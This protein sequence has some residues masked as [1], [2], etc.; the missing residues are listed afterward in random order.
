MKISTALISLSFAAALGASAAL[1]QPAADPDLPIRTGP[2]AVPAER[3][4]NPEAT[5]PASN[6]PIAYVNNSAPFPEAPVRPEAPTEA[7]TTTPLSQAE[8]DAAPNRIIEIAPNMTVG[9]RRL[10]EDKAAGGL[11]R[12]NPG[13]QRADRKSFGFGMKF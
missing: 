13:L 1:A 10:F 5:A 7:V 2:Q 3:P 11:L 4:T 8:R 12:S 6:G 9:S